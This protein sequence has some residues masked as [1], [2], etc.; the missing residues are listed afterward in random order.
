MKLRREIFFLVVALMSATAESGDILGNLDPSNDAVYEDFAYQVFQIQPSGETLSVSV[1]SSF[2]ASLILC[3]PEK[4]FHQDDG[5]GGN[6]NASIDISN[7]SPGAWFVFVTSD[8]PFQKGIYSL[9]VEG[10]AHTARMDSTVVNAELVAEAFHSRSL[11]TQVRERASRLQ[12]LKELLTLPTIRQEL[13]LKQIIVEPEELELLRNLEA[14]ALRLARAESTLF[15]GESQAGPE[16]REL[17]QEI[18]RLGAMVDQ[19]AESLA[20]RLWEKQKWVWH[21]AFGP[22]VD[23]LRI[24]ISGYEDVDQLNGPAIG[25]TSMSEGDQS[26]NPGRV[27]DSLADIDPSFWLPKLFPFPPPKAS[28]RGVLSPRWQSKMKTFGDVDD[29]I[30]DA[31]KRAGFDHPAYYGVKNGFAIVTRME[32]TNAHGAPLEGRARYSRFIAL[33]KKKWSIL[34]YLRALFTAPQGFWRVL[35]F[36]TAPPFT[37]DPEPG[38]HATISRWAAGGYAALP[39][40]VRALELSSDHRVT[41]LVYEFRKSNDKDEAFLCLD[42]CGANTLEKHLAGSGLSFR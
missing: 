9:T 21:I 30:L 37:P 11:D 19:W 40:K 23:S 35:V 16:L 15:T 3:S 18:A 38:T 27:E 14:A 20:D 6:S 24:K 31:L 4:A 26:T 12:I 41:V 2:D 32:Q 25:M 33:R 22:V 1:T 36:I 5:G 42:V 7:P 29:A 17:Q 13:H 34:E 10:A 8:Q 28:T 39:A